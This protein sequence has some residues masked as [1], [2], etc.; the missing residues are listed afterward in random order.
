MK[1]FI[2][3]PVFNR[4]DHTKKFLK[5]IRCQTLFSL[6]ELIF[7]ND[8]ST[9][10]T[11]QYLNKQ[12]DVTQIFG[13][14]NL[15]WAGAIQQGLLS[16][17]SRWG[18]GDYV[19]F[20]NNDTWFNSDYIKQL[21]SVVRS[22]PNSAVG[23]ILFEVNPVCRP[24]SLGPI[25]NINRAAVFDKLQ[26]LFPEEK[27]NLK[28][29]YRVDALSGRG[30]IFPVEL[31]QT[32]GLMRPKLLPH[33]LADYEISMRLA[34]AG[35]VLLVSTKAVIYSDPIYGNDQVHSMSIWE[36]LFS[37]R[38]SSNI[39]RIIIFYALVGSPLQRITGPLRAV[40]FHGYRFLMGNIM[41]S[42]R[43]E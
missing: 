16:A 12:N 24:V 30:V 37:T 4:L 23:S 26:F 18:S 42:I 20:L 6:I 39:F 14:G 31:F 33:Y 28:D 36:S 2:L 11:A 1:I 15:W 32:Y 10:G 22:H 34:R 7:I 43:H 13:D 19:I 9:D 17:R 40:Y 3:V 21:L 8:G 25:I 38:S 27:L 5:A 29:I 41:K 35:V